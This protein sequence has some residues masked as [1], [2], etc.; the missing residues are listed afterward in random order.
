[1]KIKILT[2]VHQ[3][4]YLKIKKYFSTA[5]RHMIQVAKTIAVQKGILEG[6]NPKSHPTEKRT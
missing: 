4:F 2:I 5:T 3:W 6:P 1:M